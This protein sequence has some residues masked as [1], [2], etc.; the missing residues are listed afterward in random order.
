MYLILGSA[1]LLLVATGILM[2][3]QNVTSKIEKENQKVHLDPPVKPRTRIDETIE[4]LRKNLEDVN[5]EESMKAAKESLK[6]LPFS[7][8]TS[9]TAQQQQGGDGLEALRALKEKKLAHLE[10]IK[11]LIRIHKSA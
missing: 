6:T 2:Y 10:E 8:P 9:A 1:G 3:Q 4:A 5:L 11:E 7:T